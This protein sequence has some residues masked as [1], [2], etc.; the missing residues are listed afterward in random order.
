MVYQKP[1]C[2]GGLD[3]FGSYIKCLS[4]NGI[5]RFRVGGWPGLRHSGKNAATANANF[6]T[7][8]DP[9][10]LRRKVGQAIF[11]LGN[12]SL[13]AQGGMDSPNRVIFVA[14]RSTKEGAN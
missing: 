8:P 3:K 6:E 12:R 10:Y 2:R 13:Q 14:D 11:K 5:A 7:G 4:G 9:L 1:A